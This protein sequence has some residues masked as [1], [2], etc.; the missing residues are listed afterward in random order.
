M[1][2]GFHGLHSSDV[3]DIP[4]YQRARA[5]VPYARMHMGQRAVMN[6]VRAR[7]R[8]LDASAGPTVQ[9]GE[10]A[11]VLAVVPAEV[12][13]FVWTPR[14]DDGAPLLDEDGD[15]VLVLVEKRERSLLTAADRFI[16]WMD[17]GPGPQVVSGL[18]YASAAAA[19]AASARWLP[20]VALAQSKHDPAGA[21]S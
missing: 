3:F 18:L 13:A 21:T 15:A 19:L 9:G 1:N 17:L 2:M 6:L 12:A 10:D 20:V 16:G 7:A 4:L 11:K 8:E 14:G 5:A